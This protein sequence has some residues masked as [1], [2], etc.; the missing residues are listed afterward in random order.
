MTIKPR[1]TIQGYDLKTLFL[2]NLM[3]L[4]DLSYVLFKNNLG[5]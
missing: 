5:V 3:K 1:E 4:L 2:L